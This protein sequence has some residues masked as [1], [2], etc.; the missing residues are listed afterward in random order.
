VPLPNDARRPS[1]GTFDIGSS[2]GAH[3]LKA[4]VGGH[5]AAYVSR[6]SADRGENALPALIGT[7][8]LK[9]FHDSF[10]SITSSSAF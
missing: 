4:S 2:A 9:V 10:M 5:D 6:G 1:G 3:E 8:E 7:I